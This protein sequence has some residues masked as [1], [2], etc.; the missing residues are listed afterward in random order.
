L[1]YSNLQKD[2]KFMI[3]MH[4]HILPGVD[5]GPATLADA[6]ELARTLVQEGVMVAMATP[7]Y[8]D[9]FS[10][11]S[12]SE[13]FARVQSLQAELTYAGIP[14]RLCIG[15]EVLIKPGLV[16]DVRRGCVATLNGSRYLLLELWSSIWLPETERFVFELREHGIIPIIA[17]PERYRAIQQEPTRLSTLLQLGAL[18]QVTLSSLLGSQRSMVRRTAEQLLRRGLVHCLASDAHSLSLRAPQ[19]LPGMQAARQ[20]L[21][22]ERV[23]FLTEIQPAAILANEVIGAPLLHMKMR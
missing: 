23:H 8:N 20:L 10:H 21:G 16:E 15:H 6:L 14:L 2:E 11:R 19:I 17:H 7:H 5:D 4:V 22:T 12:A 9:E 13:I 3:D 18:A 1:N